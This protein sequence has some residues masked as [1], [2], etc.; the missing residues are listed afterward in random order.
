VIERSIIVSDDDLID[1][2]NLGLLSPYGDAMD[3][4]DD[5]LQNTLKVFEKQ[6]ILRVLKKNNYDK[7]QAAKALG[8]GLSSLYRKMDELDIRIAKTKT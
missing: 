5:N 6:H 7:I 2:K 1:I 8:M 4:V 3:G